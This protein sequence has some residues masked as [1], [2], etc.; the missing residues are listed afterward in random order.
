MQYIEYVL[1]GDKLEEIYYICVYAKYYI[2]NKWFIMLVLWQG[3][4]CKLREYVIY[5]KRS[6]SVKFYDS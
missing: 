2:Y 1:Q 5:Y 3:Y 6:I 4:I